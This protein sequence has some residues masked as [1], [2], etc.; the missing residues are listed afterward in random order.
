MM[1]T[2]QMLSQVKIEQSNQMVGQKQVINTM[3]IQ[4]QQNMQTHVQ[5]IAQQPPN[6]I[7]IQPI[8]QQQ[9]QQQHQQ[10]V[11]QGGI[12]QQ[13]NQMQQIGIDQ[14]GQIQFMNTVPPGTPTNFNP[15]Q[16]NQQMKVIGHNVQQQ[17]MQVGLHIQ[18]IS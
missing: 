1:Q 3:M 9:Q 17:Q 10:Q 6:Q 8:Q 7:Q 13:P 2:Q 16:Q 4:G 11:N 18:W 5:N 12:V 14:S 15:V